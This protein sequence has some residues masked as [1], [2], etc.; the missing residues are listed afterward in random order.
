MTQR[1][2]NR[3]GLD[4]IESTFTDPK[5]ETWRSKPAKDIETHVFE[6]EFRRKNMAIE[7]LNQIADRL[8]E[9]LKQKQNASPALAEAIALVRGE[10]AKAAKSND[11]PRTCSSLFGG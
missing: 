3:S 1:K 7:E 8:D 10:Y 6:Y 5:R 2:L 4:F 9:K 11:A